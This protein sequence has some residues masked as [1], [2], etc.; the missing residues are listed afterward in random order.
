MLKIII[1][2]LSLLFSVFVAANSSD[3]HCNRG[4]I[5]TV[6]SKNSSKVN[7]CH[8]VNF[9]VKRSN[10]DEWFNCDS[11]LIYIE[12]KKKGNNV[13]A[14]CSESYSE[15]YRIKKEELQIR[16]FQEDYVN[17][18]IYPLVS[19][20]IQKNNFSSSYNLL[21]NF[22]KYSREKV[23]KSISKITNFETRNKNLKEVFTGLNI[24]LAYTP[25][26]PDFSIKALT[27]FKELQWFDGE[28]VEI[29]FEFINSAR[30]IKLSINSD[31]SS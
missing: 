30:L 12:D 9:K 11:V 10:Q 18:L 14:E 8:G 28:T 26:D 23:E 4:K 7:F 31:E 6:L 21:A 29:L 22:P 20:R 13:V 16:Y 15:K 3:F 1:I 27:S 5:T 24:I 17:H 19:Q 25:V 2:T